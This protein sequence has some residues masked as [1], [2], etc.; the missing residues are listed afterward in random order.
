M[1]KLNASA[2]SA[3]AFDAATNDDGGVIKSLLPSGG[4]RAEGDDD[5][6]ANAIVTSSS[7]CNIGIAT[8]STNSVVT[9]GTSG[10]RQHVSTPAQRATAASALRP[11]VEED[12]DT[13]PAVAAASSSST[14]GASGRRL[15]TATAAP[16][17]E[18]GG[19]WGSTI[20]T[21]ASASTTIG[22]I[23]G[24][25]GAGGGNATVLIQ[26][27]DTCMSL[28]QY[29]S[30]GAVVEA[31]GATPSLSFM[32]R[33]TKKLRVAAFITPASPT[34][35]TKKLALKAFAG[36]TKKDESYT[37]I[38]EYAEDEEESQ[39]VSAMCISFAGM[40]GNSSFIPAPPA[41]AALTALATSTAKAS[42]VAALS[43]YLMSTSN[44]TGD[45]TLN[46]NY[47]HLKPARLI[48]SEN[49]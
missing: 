49:W 44:V 40:E 2:T 29:G 22:G 48:S 5:N 20:S 13:P 7:F 35:V 31:N 12:E 24:G 6:T 16:V 11:S 21:V 26:R 19:G 25:G 37:A 47:G 43:A 34:G 18:G 36:L 14:G 28:S 8:D 17:G 9:A 39:D 41:S 33:V 42:A 23:G 46:T 10:T 30:S 1:S 38:V 32:D 3:T 4:M 45:P 15:S 27:S